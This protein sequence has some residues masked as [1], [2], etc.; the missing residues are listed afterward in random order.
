MTRTPGTR[1]GVFEQV[2]E[3]THGPQWPRGRRRAAA[4]GYLA[5]VGVAAFGGL[6]PGGRGTLVSAVG[7]LIV[8][9]LFVLL[10]RVTRLVADTPNAALDEILVR[11]RG[12]C[13]ALSYQVLG[14]VAAVVG[15]VLLVGGAHGLS[16]QRAAVCGLLL[17]GLALGLPAVLMA[18][19]LPDAAPRQD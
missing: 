9:M 1:E 15:A 19:T 4:F 13:F 14:A 11:L 16:A 10:R 3:A 5:A 6:I 12:E 18:L 17:L 8:I 7:A 2:R